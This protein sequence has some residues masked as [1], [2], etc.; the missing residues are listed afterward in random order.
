MYL[1]NW[2]VERFLF[3]VFIAI[4][5]TIFSVAITQAQTVPTI[6]CSTNGSIFNTAYSRD[7]GPPLQSG[8]DPEWDV[9][10]R[11]APFTGSPLPNDLTFIDASVVSTAPGAWTASPFNNANWIS[12]NST[13]SH[14][15]QSSNYDSFYRYQ[16]N[17][18]PAVDPSAFK[19]RMD[20]YSD[21]SVWDVWVNGQPQGIRSS[22]GS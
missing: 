11:T 16:F 9:A 14:P 8:F 1:Y 18:D 7:D 15:D 17:L 12:Y 22:F 21:N 10:I 3:A 6:S 20:F 4:I 13:G 5:I 19:L 2:R